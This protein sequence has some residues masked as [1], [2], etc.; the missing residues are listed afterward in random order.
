MLVSTI[1]IT[2]VVAAAVLGWQ[3]VRGTDDDSASGGGEWD[4]IALIDRSSGSIVTVGDDGDATDASTDDATND[5]ATSAD[6]LGRIT[7]VHVDGD[8]LALVGLD[9]IVLTDL[10]DEPIEVPVERG[11]DVT[12]LS[13]AEGMS[14]LIAESGGGNVVFVDGDSGETLDV[15]ELAGQANPLFFADSV[16]HDDAG[17]TFAVAD[18]ANFQTIVVTE[19]SDEPVYFADVPVAVAEEI[20]ATDQV[21]G[22]RA[23]IGLYDAEGSRLTT[24]P[25]EIPAGGLFAD[26]RLYFV[27]RQGGLFALGRDDDQPERLGS[28]TLPTGRSV[29]AVHP[30]FDSERLVVSGDGFESVVDLDGTTLFSATSTGDAISTPPGVGWSCLAVGGLETRALVSLDTGE[31]LVDLAGLEVTGASGDGCSVIGERDGIT[32]VVSAD[33]S[34]DI[35]DVRSAAL[36][37]DGRA[38]VAQ[39]ATGDVQLLKIGDDWTLEEPIDLTGLSP[40]NPLVAFLDR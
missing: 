29:R 13:T 40:V 19:Q 26:E 32:V 33:G 35:G 30:T 36:A 2:A 14:L 7:T 10:D 15:G 12:R 28:I 37:P 1:G 24:A 18:A 4:E 6:G 11:S 8:R 22:Q 23:E 17:S 9:Q 25:T 27:S 20:V 34:V 38:V 31:R 3:Y 5:Q 16:R 21:V 39:T